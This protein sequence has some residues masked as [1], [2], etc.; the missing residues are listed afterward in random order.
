MQQLNKQYVIL[1]YNFVETPHTFVITK[2]SKAYIQGNTQELNM[3]F[4]V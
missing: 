1:K 3:S 2:L 4:F